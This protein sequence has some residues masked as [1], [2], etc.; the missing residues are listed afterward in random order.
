MVLFCFVFAYHDGVAIFQLLA[1]KD[2]PLLVVGGWGGE[3]PSLSWILVHVL[4]G[5]TGFHL[6]GD[7]LASQGLLE[8]LHFDLLTNVMKP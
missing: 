6:Q 8:D 7:G 1:H 2:E 5:V 3:M 4:H